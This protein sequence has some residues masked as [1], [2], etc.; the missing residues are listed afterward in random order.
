MRVPS[1]I[2]RTH[3]GMMPPITH[4][5]LHQRRLHLPHQSIRMLAL[6]QN[7]WPRA[8][9][10]QGHL[11]TLYTMIVR[12]CTM[13]PLHNPRVNG[14][15]SADAIV[16]SLE[17]SSLFF[18]FRIRTS[19]FSLVYSLFASIL[20]LQTLTLVSFFHIFVMMSC[21]KTKWTF[22]GLAILH[23]IS[24]AIIPF[25]MFIYRYLCHDLRYGNMRR[26]Q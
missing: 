23:N 4:T 15:R 20:L 18:F 17:F 7:L 25:H 9:G 21:E 24:S 3:R 26:Q 22:G 19:C 14:E 2:I 8:P 13:W 12:L 1:R 10:V 16:T 5:M 6:P 11:K